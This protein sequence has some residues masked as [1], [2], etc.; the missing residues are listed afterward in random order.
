MQL[1][2]ERDENIKALV[3]E[4]HAALAELQAKAIAWHEDM[5]R[6]RLGDTRLCPLLVLTCCCRADR[7]LHCLSEMIRLTERREAIEVRM[8]EAVSKARATVEELEAM[9]MVGYTGR[10]RDASLALERAI[11][12]QHEN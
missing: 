6:Q 8:T 9:M 3:A 2:K 12:H 7:R 11:G 1:K 10:E 4:S 5:Q